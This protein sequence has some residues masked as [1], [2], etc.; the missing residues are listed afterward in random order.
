MRL[1]CP[2]RGTA[3]EEGKRTV[4]KPRAALFA[5][6]FQQSRTEKGHIPAA[7]PGP[8]S[9]CRHVLEPN[10]PLV[11]KVLEIVP[12]VPQPQS[13]GFINITVTSHADRRC[14]GMTW[15]G[16]H[17]VSVVLPLNP[18]PPSNHNRASHKPRLG[19]VQMSRGTPAST[20]Q[21][22]R[23]REAN[24]ERPGS[25]QRPEETGATG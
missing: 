22:C 6:V 21:F 13:T 20:L 12:P 15:P 9:G 23:R 7:G 8:G 19:G 3:G 11:L 1:Q 18:R 4:L 5:L 16:G 17:L 25:H 14:P 24:K 2:P 10:L